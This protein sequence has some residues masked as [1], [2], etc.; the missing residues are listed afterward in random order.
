MHK[1]LPLAALCFLHLCA[2]AYAGSQDEPMITLKA[3]GISLKNVF[4]SISSKTAYTFFYAGSV[5]DDKE[6]INVNFSK[7]PLSEVLNGIFRNKNVKWVITA[8]GFIQISR[9]QASVSG[10]SSSRLDPSSPPSDTLITVTGKV[11]NEKG[12]PVPAAT[13][14]V[15]GSKI[16]STTSGD[17]L[18]TIAG[19]NP[20]ASLVITNVSFLTQEL[21]IKGRSYV[22]NIS[23]KEYVGEL[24]ETVIIAYG[25]TTK[26]YNTGNVATVKAEEIEK[27]PVSNALLALQGR[28]PGV[29]ITQAT[30]VPGTAVTVRI[31]GTNSLLNGNDPLYVV[32]GVPFVSQLMP[33]LGN[34]F[35]TS[36]AALNGASQYGSPLS[37]LNV[38]DIQSIEVLKDADATAIYGSRAAN[39]A[40]L[41][42][43]KKGQPG[44]T[45]ITVNAYTGWGKVTRRQKLLD[46][47]QYLEVKNEIFKNDST[48]PNPATE[49]SLFNN[50]GWDTSRYTDWQKKLIGGTAVYNNV[51]ASISG[52]TELMQYTIGARYQRQTTVFP[53]DFTDQQTSAHFSISSGSHNK[54]FTAQLTGSYLVD[55]NQLLANDLTFYTT[56]PPTAPEIYS[57]DGSFNWALKPDG[58]NTWTNPYSQQLSQK[59]QSRTNNLIANSV[60]GY[61]IFDNLQSK[62][63]LGYTNI[64]TN[65]NK[66][67]PRTALRP[68][69]TSS[70]RSEFANNSIISWIIEPQISYNKLFKN[71]RLDVLLGAT[72]QKQTNSHEIINS[73]GYNSD[74]ALQDLRSASVIEIGSTDFSQYEYNALFARVSYA[75]KDRYLINLTARRDG[76]SR[77]GPD[78]KFSN[79]GALG[80][81]WIF[82]SEPALSNMSFLSFGKVRASYGITGS[83]QIPNYQFLDLYNARS[84]DYQGSGTL[85]IDNLFNKMLEWEETKKFETGL[86]LGLL[87]DRIFIS[88]SY[89]YNRSSNQLTFSALPLTTGFNSIAR[90]Q[91]AIIRNSGLEIALNSTN[92]SS[93]GI[94]WSSSFNLSVLRNKLVN[95]DT[96]STGIDPRAEGQPL[97][98]Q[99][100]YKSFGVDPVSGQYQFLDR[101]GKVTINPDFMTDTYPINI[102]P[103]FQGGF[104][105]TF[106]IGGFEL[107]LLFQ[108]IKQKGKNNLFAV[109]PSTANLNAPQ[110]VLDRWKTPGDQSLIQ[111]YSRKSGMSALYRLA[112]GSDAS[113]SDASFVRMKN[114][115]VSYSVPTQIKEMFKIHELRVYLQC[116]NLFTITSYKGGDPETRSFATLPPL[117]VI[118]TGIKVTL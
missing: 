16:G 96:M 19:V 48:T 82:T 76:S 67:L 115:S 81:G 27:Q 15:K 108:F 89:F 78:S 80:V 47:K 14:L 51:D 59:F 100:V 102:N 44:Q 75:L 23:L 38:S 106:T 46:T 110:T 13:V 21:P 22:G 103:S 30:G 4:D 58:T 10:G 8:D 49:Y 28:V 9:K 24:D 53:G 105:N 69:S 118:T 111:R 85:F 73:S 91:N 33:G 101:D 41:I 109:N 57:E 93:R 98:V 7:V 104:Q 50:F 56:L 83:D 42:T 29:E 37:Y 54:R 36:G 79:F 68:G 112:N 31:R 60:L 26:R 63:S 55:N 11:V 64:Q 20:N 62:V 12:E 99:F 88:T 5:I 113:Y 77:F 72:V 94:K 86:E 43:T 70:R 61:K 2:F 35:G 117:R 18:F 84:I 32:D 95:I 97:S 116:Q 17:G 52:G 6:K 90:N 87:R 92:I 65:D 107:D 3:K 1:L 66:I 74:A 114:L 40:I 39:G 71:S 34:I 45:R 25:T